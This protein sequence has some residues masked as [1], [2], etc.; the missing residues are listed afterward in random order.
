MIAQSKEVSRD[1]E[2][3]GMLSV[4]VFS[5]KEVLWEGEAQS[6]SSVNSQGPFDLLP[7]HAHFISLVVK[8]PI[9]VVTNTETK[10]FSFE[11]AVVRLLDDKVTIFAEIS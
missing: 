5:P 7:E 2:R 10:T 3:A 1:V 6:V 4:E 9:T 8:Q 11:T